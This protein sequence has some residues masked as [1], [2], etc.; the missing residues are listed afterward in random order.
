MKWY[1]YV[2]AV[3]M[4]L[5][6]ELWFW[7]VVIVITI[8]GLMIWALVVSEHSWQKFSVEH[9]CKI[10][11]RIAG[12]VISTTTI[13]ADGKLGVGLATIPEKVGYLCNDGITHW[14]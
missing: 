8:P 3:P 14:R 13:G 9:D 12:S 7:G 2:W 5:V 10:T 11:S 1:E 4:W 6:S